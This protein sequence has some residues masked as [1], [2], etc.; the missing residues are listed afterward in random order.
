MYQQEIE[1]F[2]PLTEQIKLDLDYTDCDNPKVWWTTEV[3][4]TDNN[5]FTLIGNG[6][7]TVTWSQRIGDWEIPSETKQPNNLQKFM[8]K[9]L[10]GWKWMGK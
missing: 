1:F 7:G 8:M 2:W 9:Y 6:G 10:I 3:L 4:G 5:G